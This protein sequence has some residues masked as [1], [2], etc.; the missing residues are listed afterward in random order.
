MKKTRSFSRRMLTIGALS[1]ATAL[2]GCS[3]VQTTGSG[4]VGVDRK[5]YMSG[6]VSEQALEQVNLSNAS[7][8][9]EK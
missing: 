6:M 9:A 2:A 4:A 7:T 3:A 5:Q 8:E 1:I